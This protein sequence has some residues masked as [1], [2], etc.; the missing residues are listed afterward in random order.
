MASHITGHFY[1]SLALERGAPTHLVQATLAMRRWPPRAVTCTPGQRTAAHGIWECKKIV[2]LRLQFLE[3]E[4]REGLEPSLNEEC[5]IIGL[6]QEGVENVW[7][8]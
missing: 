5:G 1:A 6:G 7:G 4:A 2:N 8:R 3:T